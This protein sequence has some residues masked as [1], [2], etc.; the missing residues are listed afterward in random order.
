MLESRAEK[1]ESAVVFWESFISANIWEVCL[2][3][4]SF[5]NQTEN[6]N[7]M[8]KAEEKQQ[9]PDLQ[10]ALARQIKTIPSFLF[11]Y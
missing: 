6:G 10:F 9:V 4:N 7:N 11:Y 2:C 1:E 8:R 3:N 5:W